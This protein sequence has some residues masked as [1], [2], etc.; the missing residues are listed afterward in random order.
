MMLTTD[1][2]AHPSKTNYWKATWEK[3]EERYAW[4]N[5]SQ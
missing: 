3:K 5:Y 1:I 4:I 2:F